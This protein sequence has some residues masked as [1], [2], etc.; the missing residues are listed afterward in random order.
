MTTS[1]LTTA[2]SVDMVGDALNM[3]QSDFETGMIVT[4]VR[5]GDIGGGRGP[6]TFTLRWRPATRSQA[7]HVRAH[8]QANVH[9][10]FA[11]SLPGISPAPSCIY[12]NA[13]QI[14]HRTANSADIVVTL[15]EALITD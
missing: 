7:D 14:R 13:P 15:E 3:A 1:I 2:G 11:V 9:K 5:N 10:A 4:R 8:Y 6:R 12:Q